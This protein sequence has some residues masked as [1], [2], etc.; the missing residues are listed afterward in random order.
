MPRPFTIRMDVTNDGAEPLVLWVEPW[1]HDF[2]LA[3]GQSFALV[4]TSET[5]VPYFAQRTCG[6]SRDVVIYLEGPDDISFKVLENGQ[7]LHCG[8]NRIAPCDGALPNTSLERTRE[9]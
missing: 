3:A 1:A 6:T 9:R 8:H 5:D 4:A 2:T 7:E